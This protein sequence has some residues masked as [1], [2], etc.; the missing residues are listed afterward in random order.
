MQPV[1]LRP[2]DFNPTFSPVTQITRRCKLGHI[3]FIH[4]FSASYQFLSTIPPFNVVS[5][6]SFRRVQIFCDS[7]LVKS[8]VLLLIFEKLIGKGRWQIRY[9]IRVRRRR[10]HRKRERSLWRSYDNHVI[11]RVINQLKTT[12][13]T[14]PSEFRTRYHQPSLFF[15][16][17]FVRS[18]LSFFPFTSIKIFFYSVQP[19]YFCSLPSMEEEE[20]EASR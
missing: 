9:E 5:I 8:I 10:R 15:F 20:E 19:D 2:F 12:K 18:F 16:F 1:Y 4:S 7:S 14:T 3:S 13:V 6:P 11:A 17:S